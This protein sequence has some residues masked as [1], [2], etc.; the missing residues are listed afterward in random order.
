TDIIQDVLFD[1][2]LI[3]TEIYYGTTTTKVAAGVICFHLSG[4]EHGLV[5]YLDIPHIP[6]DGI[7]LCVTAS[8]LLSGTGYNAA[9]AQNSNKGLEIVDMRSNGQSQNS[10]HIHMESGDTNVRGGIYSGKGT[11]IHNTYG[12]MNT[13]G[14]H[15]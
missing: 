5:R 10:E 12:Q 8:D 11:A 1:N 15:H 9:R 2:V 6:T 14:I 4:Y 7:G 13:F 3:D